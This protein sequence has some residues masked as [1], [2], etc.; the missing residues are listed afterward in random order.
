MMEDLEHLSN[1][2]FAR[3]IF[4]GSAC[5]RW[6]RLRAVAGQLHD[7]SSPGQAYVFLRQLSANI[8]F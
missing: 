4:L 8:D 2:I 3:L 6:P 7:R 1:Q 5:H